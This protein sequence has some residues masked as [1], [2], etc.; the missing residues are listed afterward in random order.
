MNSYLY[1]EN[2]N[3]K[4]QLIDQKYEIQRLD[5]KIKDLEYEQCKLNADRNYPEKYS[6]ENKKARE[7]CFQIRW[8]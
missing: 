5:S 1:Y 8:N 2:K 4:H 6:D 3:L 7:K